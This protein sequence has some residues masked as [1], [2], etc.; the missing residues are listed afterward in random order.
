MKAII[1]TKYGAPDV[2]KLQEIAKPVP[3]DKEVLVKIAATT[4]NSGDCRIRGLRAP[5]LLQFVMRLI[6]GLRRPKQPI[7]GV[8]LAGE[9]EAIGKDVKGFRAGDRVFAFTGMNSGGT[10]TEY[11]S[12]PE[13]GFTLLLP[14]GVSYEEGAA[15]S[16]GGTSA[17]HF[18]RKAGIRKGQ[19]VL[20][21]G[22]SGAVGTA[23]VQLAK[24]YGTEVTGVCGP[25]N[26][27]LIR[28][29]GADRVMDYTKEDFTK[30]EERYDIIF[31]AVGKITKSRCR[32]ALAPNGTFVTVEGLE[33]AKVR[34]DD[35]KL[36]IT[37]MEEGRFKPVIDRRYRLEQIPEA[38]RYVDE[39]HKI[40]SVI[41]T[42]G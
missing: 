2:L 7:L 28:S 12:L 10:Y 33:V 42:V 24:Y 16:F 15:L 35:L 23:A 26:V 1:C 30:S 13:G 14:D 18:F 9:I 6:V 31:D 5:L 34:R 3:G 11:V 41:I 4:V 22:A 17:L 20:I 36:L 27:D 8:E 21:Y 32:K 39:G 37:L 19:K 29:L 40:G 38:H 25:K